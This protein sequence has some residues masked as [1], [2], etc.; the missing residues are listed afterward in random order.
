[1]LVKLI[2]CAPNASTT[3]NDVAVEN[4]IGDA[5][6]NRIIRA[7]HDEVKWRA[8]IVIPLLPGFTFPIDHNDASAVNN[9]YSSTWP[10][11]IRFDRYASLWSV[12]TGRSRVVPIQFLHG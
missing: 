3:V 8:V 6:V 12:R 10:L 11:L 5:L 4:K 7:H 2:D 9:F 1:M